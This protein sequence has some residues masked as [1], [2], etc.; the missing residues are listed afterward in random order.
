M[1]ETV[2]SYKTVWTSHPTS[3]HTRWYLQKYR[4]TRQQLE[5][6]TIVTT[7]SCPTKCPCNK[8]ISWRD[9][10]HKIFSKTHTGFDASNT[11]PIPC[12]GM[13]NLSALS[14]FQFQFVIAEYGLKL[15]TS[16]GK[17]ALCTNNWS[18]TFLHKVNCI[19]ILPI[20]ILCFWHW[21]LRLLHTHQR[22]GL[23][24][25]L[26]PLN[27]AKDAWKMINTDW[28]LSYRSHF[29]PKLT[30]SQAV[31]MQHITQVC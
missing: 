3:L 12:T 13:C 25:F 21:T 24:A 26:L 8:N 6:Y 27:N 1:G 10:S 14:T 7:S 15:G 30:P 20:N 16:P 5:I 19:V 22:R 17:R 11:T 31:S 28:L 4:A 2:N 18:N 29:H 9:H 23:S